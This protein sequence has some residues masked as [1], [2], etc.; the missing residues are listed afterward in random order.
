MGYET[1][2]GSSLPEA[3]KDL[4]ILHPDSNKEYNEDEL[5]ALRSREFASRLFLTSTLIPLPEGETCFFDYEGA[6]L[7]NRFSDRAPH[8]SEFRYIRD[9]LWGA[10]KPD[11]T[12]AK[13]ALTSLLLG[14]FKMDHDKYYSSATLLASALS[15]QAKNT[16][17]QPYQI[18]EGDDVVLVRR[19]FVLLMQILFEGIALENSLIKEEQANIYRL[20]YCMV[21]DRDLTAYLYPALACLLQVLLMAYVV[22]EIVDVT[23]NGLELVN[24]TIPLAI[25]GSMFSCVQA[26]KGLKSTFGVQELYEKGFSLMQMLDLLINAFLPIVAVGAGFLLIA[27]Q[28]GLIDGVLNTAAL[29][30]IPEIDDELPELLDLDPVDIIHIHLVRKSL[31]SY[32]RVASMTN[33]EIDEEFL[34]SKE[35][36]PGD[37]EFQD[38]IATNMPEMGSDPEKFFIYAPHE[39][40]KHKDV[41]G[42]GGFVNPSTVIQKDSLLKEISWIYQP[43][44]I[45]TKGSAKLS[46]GYI[47]YLK[48]VK[49]DDEIIEIVNRKFSDSIDVSKPDGSVQGIYVITCFQKARNVTKL[50]FCGSKTSEDFQRALSYYSLWDLSSGAK[51]SLSGVR[52]AD[53]IGKG[54]AFGSSARTEVMGEGI[55]VLTYTKPSDDDAKAVSTGQI[56]PELTEEIEAFQDPPTRC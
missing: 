6:F 50:R 43:A 44:N 5:R 8:E 18:I 29:L 54:S 48:L 19:K 12:A 56:I 1:V 17:F 55:T 22:F 10:R 33:K 31:E 38:I 40:F 39:C 49:L 46:Q 25:A 21:N 3:E 37:I 27:T 16:S 13:S 11:H 30:F 32:E 2:L 9:Y 36:H 15:E 14:N 24:S 45:K 41:S 20:G 4:I 53:G 42:D 51:K 7:R 26:W 28:D 52:D 47:V 35:K 23:S 34:L